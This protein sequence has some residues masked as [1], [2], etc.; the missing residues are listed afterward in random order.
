MP[1]NTL[2]SFR[3][4]MALGADGYEL[5]VA[6]SS[7]GVPVVLH[8]DTLQRTTNGSGPVTRHS[9]AELKRLDAGYS[10]R[11][12]DRFAGERIPTLAEVFEA[13][14]PRDIINVELKRDRVP[15]RRLADLAVELIHA[16]GM[17]GRVLVS[18][19]QFSNLRR[20]KEIEPRLPVAVIYTLSALA[21]WI[22]R[23]LASAF[24]SEAHHPYHVGLSAE[25]IAW[26][27]AHGYRV[28]ARTVNEAAEL[29]RLM[30]AGVDGVFTDNPDVA[31][32]V[33]ESLAPPAS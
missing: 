33:R 23:Q 25:R 19:F 17:A 21:P 20:V 14:G 24:P 9:L 27:H 15:R 18:S 11:F 4:A 7:D 5:D 30:A 8:D 3:Q 31:A 10:A 1:E 2:A 12:G 6:L 28:N 13:A 32:G 26:Y 29:R 16:H 22:E